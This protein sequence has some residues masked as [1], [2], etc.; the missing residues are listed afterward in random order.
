MARSFLAWRR[1]RSLT[2]SR[3]ASATVTT[4][5]ALIKGPSH[6]LAY[7]DA[8]VLFALVEPELVLLADEI[9]LALLQLYGADARP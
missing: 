5:V 7:Q 2:C 8:G 1:V 3:T 9:G 6:R 4:S